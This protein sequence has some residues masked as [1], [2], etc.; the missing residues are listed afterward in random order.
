M[1]PTAELGR[2]QILGELGRGSMGVVFH[3]RDTLLGR[4]VALKSVRPPVSGGEDLRGELL[5]EARSAGML[6]HPNVVTIYDVLEGEDGALY[7]AMEYVEGRSLADVLAESGPLDLERTVDVVSH[8]AAALDYLHA[9]GLVHRDVKPGN[10]LLTRDGRV[11]ITDFGIAVRGRAPRAGRGEERAVQE[12][13][14]EEGAVLGTPSYMAPEQILGREITPQTDVWGLGVV[15]Y[16]MLTGSRPF[17]GRSV[18]DVVHRIVHG[19]VPRIGDE[20]AHP[21]RLR[22]LLERALAKDPRWRFPSAGDLARDLRKILYEAAGEVGERLSDAEM[23]DRTLVSHRTAGS[24]V[25]RPLWRRP[26]VAVA[27]LATLLGIAAFGALRM[28]RGEDGDRAVLTPEVAELDARSM[29]A[30][31]LLQQG[32]RLAAAGDTEG[33]AVFFEV[34]ERLETQLAQA[35]RISRLRLRAEAEV[36]ADAPEVALARSALVERDPGDLLASARRLLES[37]GDDAVETRVALDRAGESLGAR[38]GGDGAAGDGREA[39]VR[40]EF[41][42]EAPKGVLTIYG[43]GHQLLRRGFSYYEPVWLLG[44]RPTS[45]GFEEQLAVPADVD[46]LWVYVARPE[47][48]AH[49][50][51]VPGE[52]EPGELRVLRV[53]LPAEG[54][55]TAVLR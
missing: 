1:S 33:A 31:R 46:S 16:E 5:R 6:S 32:Q 55:A 15:L 17:D 9:M 13:A 54:E 7:I 37:R 22:E 3:A 19:P 14:D 12:L 50:I 30:L 44:R 42:S 18:A 25:R 45:G 4:E 2:Y 11:K 39:R 35:D 34:V 10:I 47:A 26:S 20:S 27:L 8:V 28:L 53:H 29:E 24:A 38:Q 49:R 41:S 51:E 48:A 52:Y 43:G 21:T 40:V 36:R 23:L